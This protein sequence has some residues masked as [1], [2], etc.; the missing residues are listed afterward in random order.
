M[1]TAA[2]CALRRA[3]ATEC[4]CRARG[5][6]EVIDVIVQNNVANAFNGDYR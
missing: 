6:G 4:V 1:A 2:L 3:V 5:A